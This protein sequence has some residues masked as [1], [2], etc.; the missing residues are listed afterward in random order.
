MV[1]AALPVYGDCLENRGGYLGMEAGKRKQKIKD[2]RRQAILEA[3]RVLLLENG[4]D[5]VSIRQIAE[6]SDLGL[7]TIYSYFSGKTEIYATLSIEVFDLIHEHLAAAD[8]PDITPPDRIRSIG[9]ALLEFS[10]KHK[11]YADFLDYFVSSSRRI[12]PLQMKSHIDKH[13]EKI[14]APLIAA[15]E[16]GMESGAFTRVDARQYALI[17]LGMLHGI[18]HLRKLQKTMLSGYRF[19]ELYN[20]AVECMLDSL[21]MKQ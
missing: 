14:L 19:E 12:F 7:G 16:A 1:E 10:V 18:T 13:G 21:R 3:A 15:I 4:L 5:G 11:A 9:K 6:S 2:E 17:F 20:Q 8:S